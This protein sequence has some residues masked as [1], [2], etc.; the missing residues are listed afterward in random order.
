MYPTFSPHGDWVVI[1]RRY[2]NGKNIQVG[3][4]VRYHHPNILG[5]HAAKRVLGMP[6]D[7]VCVDP[8]YSTGAGTQPDMIQVCSMQKLPLWMKNYL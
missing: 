3:D 5:G 7:F 2:A 6:G 1:S 4:V 8:P